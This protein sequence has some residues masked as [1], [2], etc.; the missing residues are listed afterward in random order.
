ME[1]GFSPDISAFW[2][3]LIVGGLGAWVA[4]RQIQLRLGGIRGIWFQPRTWILFIAYLAVP[5]GLFWLLDRTG[6]TT[7]TSLFAAV[8]VG[9]GYERIISGQSGTLRAA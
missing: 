2:C 4:G 7:D 3:Y 6:A 9:I 1:L 5:V 8:L